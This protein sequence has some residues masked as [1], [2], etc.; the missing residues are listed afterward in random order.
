MLVVDGSFH[1]SWSRD[2]AISR[3]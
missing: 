2:Q 1:I 3:H